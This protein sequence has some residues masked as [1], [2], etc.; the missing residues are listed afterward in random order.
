MPKNIFHN[1][2]IWFE[3]S[4]NTTIYVLFDGFKF[5]V[6]I[7]KFELIKYMST[8]N[9]DELKEYSQLRDQGIIT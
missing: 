8:L 4:I 9:A 6:D 1:K 7:K 3:K 2:Y 5:N